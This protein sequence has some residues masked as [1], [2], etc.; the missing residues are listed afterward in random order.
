MYSSRYSVSRNGKTYHRLC[1]VLSFLLPIPSHANLRAPQCVRAVSLDIRIPQSTEFRFTL[2]II[3]FP[4]ENNPEPQSPLSHPTDNDPGNEGS[5]DSQTHPV[6]PRSLT[7]P[8]PRRGRR[9]SARSVP[10]MTWGEGRGNSI[11]IQ[12]L[13]V[14]SMA[15]AQAVRTNFS[16][17]LVPEH[18]VGKPPNFM[19]GLRI[20]FFGSCTS[21]Y[22]IRFSLYLAF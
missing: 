19:Y 22:P 7:G 10:R 9:A 16:Y 14:S 8:N 2:L 6:P 4:A 18:R 5:Q 11:S 20:I 21:S 13:R 1:T 17:L 15:T 12:D 3:L